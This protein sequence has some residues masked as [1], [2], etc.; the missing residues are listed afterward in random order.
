MSGSMG[1]GDML[2]LSAI[3][4]TIENNFQ[5]LMRVRKKQKSFK[6]LVK[7]DF[8]HRVDVYGFVDN[9]DVMMDA[10]DCVVTKA[11]GL[12]VTEALAKKLPMIIVNYIPGQEEYNVNFLINNG[13]ALYV[14]KTF[15]IGEAVYYLLNSPQRLELVN[16]SIE[17]VSHPDAAERLTDFIFDSYGDKK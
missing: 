2:Q 6:K 14:T 8:S 3:L 17:L 9:V 10:S 15:S 4:I 11:G 13:L 1:F 7:H 12:T 16:R 5:I